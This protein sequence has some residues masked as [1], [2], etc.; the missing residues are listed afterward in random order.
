MAV[1][2]AHGNT[3]GSVFVSRL[4]FLRER[5]GAVLVERVLDRL[6]PA[7]REV[8]RGIVLPA[9]WYP[10]ELN[11]RLDEAIVSCLEGGDELF[12]ELG[13]QSALHNLTTTHRNYIRNHDPHG[14]FRQ[15]ASI[16]RVYYDTG[17]REYEK[18]GQTR[19]VLRT[20]GSKSF[21]RTDCLTVV[22]YHEQ[23]ILMCG[24]HDPRVEEPRCRV[25]GDSACEYLLAWT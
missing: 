2:G 4:K 19:A 12:R 8:L 5:G 23:A 6:P 13:R 18:V 3:K 7:D 16:Y 20:I 1:E 15:A 11:E 25:R 17:S 22:G 21:S 10:F 9:S 24:G 14:L